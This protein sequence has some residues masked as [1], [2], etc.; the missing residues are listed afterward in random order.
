MI[1]RLSFEATRY[2]RDTLGIYVIAVDK[3]REFERQCWS[4]KEHMDNREAP[5]CRH[6]VMDL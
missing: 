4:F 3:F 2:G 1:L 6:K 5:T